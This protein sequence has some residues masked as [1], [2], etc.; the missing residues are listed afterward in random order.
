[1]TKKVAISM[2]EPMFREVE[3]ARKRTSRASDRS[4]WIQEAI[5]ERLEREKHQADVAAYIRG[6]ELYPETEEE[7]AEAEAW[8]KLGPLYDEDWPEAPAG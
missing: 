6:Y 4:A 8:L 3:R 1:M 2:P 7:I 5:A